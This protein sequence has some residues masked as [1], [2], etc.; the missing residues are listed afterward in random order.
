MSYVK[1]FVENLVSKEYPETSIHTGTYKY[2]GKTYDR[3]EVFSDGHIIQA[4]VLMSEEDCKE[5]PHKFPFYR[6]Y[7]QWNDYGYLTLPACNVAVKNRQTGKWE[8]HSASD[9]KHEITSPDFLNYDEAVKRFKTR[10][11]FSG[12]RRF[13]R[14]TM[15]LSISGLII[16]LLYL[17]AHIL[18]VNGVFPSI[19]IPM[20]ATV[21]TMLIVVIL[22]L[23]FPWL[24]PY[25]KSIS[26][27]GFGLEINQ[28]F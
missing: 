21:V 11:E 5:P 19:E 4:F 8:I 12:D 17:F 1:D 13:R 2:D 27:N 14:L 16:V 18:S 22:L 25:I 15:W 10:W 24:M 6:T 3:V 20:N 28:E 26:V 7:R 9:L 23:F